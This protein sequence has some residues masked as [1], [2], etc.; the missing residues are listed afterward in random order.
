MDVLPLL[1]NTRKSESAKVD[2]SGLNFR[3]DISTFV[4]SF[5]FILQWREYNDFKYKISVCKDSDF[6]I[7]L[8]CL[9]SNCT[10]GVDNT[11]ITRQYLNSTVLKVRT[12][13]KIG[14][15]HFYLKLKMPELSQ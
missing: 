4:D 10:M 14:I 13:K 3:L 12:L 1:H 11:S 7:K 5:L 9:A 2:V 15:L 8:W 6:D